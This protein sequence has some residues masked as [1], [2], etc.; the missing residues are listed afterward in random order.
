MKGLRTWQLEQ[1]GLHDIDAHVHHEGDHTMNL[2]RED[3]ETLRH[4]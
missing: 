3:E 1:G 2:W 4:L